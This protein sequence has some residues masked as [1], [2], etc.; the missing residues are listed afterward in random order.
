VHA[1]VYE[2]YAYDYFA[3]RFTVLTINEFFVVHVR[4]VNFMSKLMNVY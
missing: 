3:I 2:F 1:E 4:L